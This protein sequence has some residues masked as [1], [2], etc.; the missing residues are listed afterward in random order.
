VSNVSRNDLLVET[1]SVSHATTMDWTGA[2]GAS[3]VFGNLP[4]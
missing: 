4:V 2:E 3:R 1:D